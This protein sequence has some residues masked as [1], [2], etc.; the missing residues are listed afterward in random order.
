MQNQQLFHTLIVTK[1][2]H[3]TIIHEKK[4][5]ST[6][7]LLEKTGICYCSRLRN[8]LYCAFRENMN[9]IGKDR[10]FFLFTAQ[11]CAVLRIP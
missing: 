9:L 2:T 11:E 4:S 6:R 5:V 8:A 7:I 1:I 10:L 3:I